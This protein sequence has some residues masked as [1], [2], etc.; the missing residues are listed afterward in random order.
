M[1][2]RL[3]GRVALITG[4]SRG[5]GA[6]VAR[7]FAREGA[8]V[9][10]MARSKAGLEEVDD[11][12]RAAGGEATLMP[13]DLTKIDDLEALGPTILERFGKLDIFVANAG[14]LGT[15]T[16]VSHSKMKDWKDTWTTN[17]LAN[18]QMIRTLEPLLKASDAG[19][20]MVVGS[21]IG[22]NPTAFWG[23][24]G[25]SKSAAMFLFQTWAEETRQTNLRV[26]VVRPGIVDTEMLA[27]AYPGGAQG[28]G[29]KLRTPDEVAPMFLEL[30]L[31]S[32][33]RHGELAEP[34]DY[35]L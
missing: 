24:Y 23:E 32:C 34:E 11:Q 3:S 25:V 5:I 4:A 26:N 21:G 7:L 31:P 14:V 12:I 30:A 33:E 15:L 35:G 18:V 19:R 1:S 2:Q 8:H 27:K 20:A 22:L 6:A 9:I 17:V 13:F 16:P 28:I 10:L 29:K